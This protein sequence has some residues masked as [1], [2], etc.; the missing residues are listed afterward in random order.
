[1]LIKKEYTCSYCSEKFIGFD[2]YNTYICKKCG[3]IVYACDKCRNHV[4][5][6]SCGGNL[7]L[8]HEWSCEQLN[9]DPRNLIY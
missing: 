2:P 6:C 7:Q 1:M 3:K 5:R 9:V 8:K 4:T